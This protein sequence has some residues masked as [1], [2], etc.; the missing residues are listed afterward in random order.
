MKIL[1]YPFT[2]LDK[3][4][5]DCY[6]WREILNAVGSVDESLPAMLQ[7][8]TVD[9]VLVFDVV[10]PETNGKTTLSP[11]HTWVDYRCSVT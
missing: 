11:D 9:E 8:R 1:C 4:A 10:G 6:I 5:N 3:C 2:V 7:R